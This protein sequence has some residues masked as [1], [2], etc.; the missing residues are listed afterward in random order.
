MRSKPRQ[1]YE[2]EG[3]ARL[4]Q[5]RAILAEAYPGLSFCIDE[6]T[7][8]VRLEGTITLV[9]ECGMRT[10]LEVLVQLARNHP[11]GEPRAY[12]TS[13][14][15]PRVPDRH[16]MPDGRCCL[17]LPP[18]SQ[19]DPNDP[20]RLPKYLDQVALFFERQLICDVTGEWPGPER[21]HGTAGYMEFVGEILN[22][23]DTLVQAIAPVLGGQNI[24]RNTP[25]PCGSGV[26]YKRC[27]LEI[28]TRIEG[29]VGLD[30]LRDVFKDRLSRSSGGTKLAEP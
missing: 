8:L 18:E 11:F 10:R 9:A 16:L 1:W 14:R 2:Q 6:E 27:H 28:V 25:C 15:F 5:E 17:W 21:G 13:G 22:G 30:R 23:D 3:G 20:E 29:T 7:G 4:A 24:G 12:D 19:W 26:K